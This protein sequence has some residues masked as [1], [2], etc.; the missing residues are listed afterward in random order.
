MPYNYA[1]A[2]ED[3]AICPRCRDEII[4]AARIAYQ[5]DHPDATGEVQLRILLEQKT[6]EITGEDVVYFTFREL[7]FISVC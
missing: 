4:F 3:H 5:L 6:V 2:F 7:G 1:E